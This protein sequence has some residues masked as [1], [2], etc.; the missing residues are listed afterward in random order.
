MVQF[1]NIFSLLKMLVI[2]TF[3]MRLTQ[4]EVHLRN[5]QNKSTHKLL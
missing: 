1:R 4:S 5:I 3:M 2:I